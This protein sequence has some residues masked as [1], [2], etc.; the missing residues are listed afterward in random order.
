MT[1]DDDRLIL[2]K[3]INYSYMSKFMIQKKVFGWLSDFIA[4]PGDKLQLN[5][6]HIINRVQFQTLIINSSGTNCTLVLNDCKTD[7]ALPVQLMRINPK[8]LLGWAKPKRAKTLAPAP[9]PKPIM[10]LTCKKSNT[11]TKS[12]PRVFND[13]NWKLD[14]Q[15]ALQYHKET[16]S[17]SS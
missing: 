4:L 12:S 13:G 9:S 10:Y 1:N 5:K 17:Q 15:F 8:H 16:N 3:L 6:Q 14:L 11:V 7:A 2:I